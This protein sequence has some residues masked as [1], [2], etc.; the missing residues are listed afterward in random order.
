MIPAAMYPE[1]RNEHK[2]YLGHENIVATGWLPSAIDDDIWEP[3]AEK[4]TG[5]IRLHDLSEG[6]FVLPT[7]GL[8]DLDNL[9]RAQ[10]L[11][12]SYACQLHSRPCEWGCTQ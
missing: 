3:E 11:G 10:S 9:S 5:L 6:S 8:P 7:Y 2:A 12:H 4:F 1:T